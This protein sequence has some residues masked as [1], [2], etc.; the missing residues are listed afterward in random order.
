MPEAESWDHQDWRAF[1]EETG[2]N[3]TFAEWSKW[4]DEVEAELDFES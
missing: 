1:C 3:W 4:M 2:E